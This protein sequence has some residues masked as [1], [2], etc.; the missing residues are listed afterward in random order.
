MHFIQP[1]QASGIDALDDPY[2]APVADLGAQLDQACGSQLLHVIMNPPVVAPAK[3]RKPVDRH[4]RGRIDQL[5]QLALLLGQFCHIC[6]FGGAKARW[7]EK[8]PFGVCAQRRRRQRQSAA[9]WNKK[10]RRSVS[11]TAGLYKNPGIDL[12]SHGEP[13]ST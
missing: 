6:H 10:T 8:S 12:L 11:S 3:L 13:H 5:Q 7:Q 9:Q 2:P 4:R 1:P